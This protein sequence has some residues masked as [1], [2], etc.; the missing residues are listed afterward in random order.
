MSAG[1]CRPL[2]SP[3][4]LRLAVVLLLA[5]PWPESEP[6]LTGGGAGLRGADAQQYMCHTECAKC[7]LFDYDQTWHCIECN[8]GLELWVDGCFRPCPLGQYRYGY[9]CKSCTNYCNHCVG[10]MRHE[11]SECA[12]GYGFDMRSVCVRQC[13]AGSFPTLDGSACDECNAYCKTCISGY[14]IS[15]TACFEGY[16]LRVLDASTSSGECMQVCPVGYYRDSTT[17]LRCIQ[18]GKYCLRCDSGETCFKCQDTA[19]LYRGLCY[20]IPSFV[21]NA[22]IDFE[23]YMNS[24]AGMQVDINDPTRP[25]WENLIQGRRLHEDQMCGREDS[26][27]FQL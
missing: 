17:D 7:H 21:Q 3:L 16:T 14:R 4:R 23:S 2:P 8:T 20:L 6:G 25:T 24:G 13:E 27:A 10:S 18:C 15:C 5:G 1:H 26:D 22:D 11:C 19:T 9:E 12:R